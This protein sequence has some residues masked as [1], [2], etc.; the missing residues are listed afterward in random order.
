MYRAP[1]VQ[2]NPK[3]KAG[4]TVKELVKQNIL[5]RDCEKYFCTKAGIPFTFHYHQKQAFE[6]AKRQE[7]YVVNRST[8]ILLVNR[9][10]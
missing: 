2:L 8:S 5:H 10:S 4:A 3:Y 6:T 1:L 9:K 7:P